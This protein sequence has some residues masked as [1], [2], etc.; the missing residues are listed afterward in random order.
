M[1]VR[2]GVAGAERWP[3]SRGHSGTPVLQ[4]FPCPCATGVPQ[5][6][7]T[8]IDVAIAGAP[9]RD[10]GL[11]DGKAAILLT[12]RGGSYGQGSPRAG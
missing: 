6:V 9:Y 4:F 11:P 5:Q 7:K 8:W 3:S 10:E 12:T 2:R 1:K